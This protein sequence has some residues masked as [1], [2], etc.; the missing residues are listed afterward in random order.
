MRVRKQYSLSSRFFDFSTMSEIGGIGGD[1]EV[2]NIMEESTDVES[3]EEWAKHPV[4]VLWEEWKS[5]NKKGK[6]NFDFENHR[7]AFRS[8]LK[9][10]AAE[11][12]CLDVFVTG[13]DRT[14]TCM[15][16]LRSE[17]DEIERVVGALLKFATKTKVERNHVMA[18]WI[19]YAQAHQATGAGLKAYLLPGGKT[20]ICQHALTR[21]CGMKSYAWRGLC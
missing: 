2:A 6:A 1:N 5:S 21:V 9:D 3:I 17:E 16:Y 15:H 10:V 14:C 4:S 19:R 8:F 20:L 11:P 13:R 12:N 7:E 18:E